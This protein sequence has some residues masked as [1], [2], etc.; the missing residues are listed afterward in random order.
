MSIALDRSTS[1]SKW[2]AARDADPGA[3][4]ALLQEQIP[5]RLIATPRHLLFTCPSDEIVADVRRR[6]VEHYDFVP[7]V[8][9]DPGSSGIVGLLRL[10]PAPPEAKRHEQASDV[11]EALCETNLIG[12]DAD[13]LS[14]VRNADEHPCRLVVQGTEI[15]GLISLSDLQR[16][17]VRAALFATITHFEMTMAALIKRQHG[18][19][20]G[21]LTRL[22]TSRQKKLSKEIAKS[23]STDSFVDE[24]L[25]TQFGDKVDIIDTGA[26]DL[27]PQFKIDAQKIMRLRNLLAH[28]NEYAASPSAAEDV[29][30]TVR[31]MDR[32]STR[33]ETL[34]IGG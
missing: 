30:V 32:W 25:F 28:A 3:A 18:D 11:M 31:L 5:I 21:W 24:L 7:V 13:I 20:V 33:L 6:N 1:R 22:D 23:K 4:L 17:P 8:K 10:N 16:L 19:G 14:F 26:L 34:A 2:V 9:R 12:A 27:G 29:C 15:S